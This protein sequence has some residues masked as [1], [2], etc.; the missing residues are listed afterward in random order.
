MGHGVYSTHM[1][2]KPWNGPKINL[3]PTE[4]ELKKKVQEGLQADGGEQAEN[5]AAYLE[6]LQKQPTITLTPEEQQ[7]IEE[8]KKRE[9]GLA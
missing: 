3:A 1:F 7:E 2:E 5:R 8:R 6:S 9:G 4:E